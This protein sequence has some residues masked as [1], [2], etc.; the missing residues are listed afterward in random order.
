MVNKRNVYFYWKSKKIH[1]P[2]K[3]IIYACGA[4][5]GLTGFASDREGVLQ[6]LIRRD[7]DH[8]YG[9][10][11]IR[12]PKMGTNNGNQKLGN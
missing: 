8:N 12:G 5:V 7:M 4:S 9:D 11:P 1:S 10:G 3:T 6:I 2:Q